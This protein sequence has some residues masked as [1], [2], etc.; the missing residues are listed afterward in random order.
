MKKKTGGKSAPAAGPPGRRGGDPAAAPPPPRPLFFSIPP[1]VVPP[2][3]PENHA[4]SRASLRRPRQSAASTKHLADSLTVFPRR[5]QDIGP[6]AVNIQ[7]AGDHKQQIGKAVQIFCG[8][9]VYLLRLAKMNHAS[10]RTPA[11][12]ARQMAHGGGLRSTGQDKFL[13]RR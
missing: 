7:Y 9:R 5:P 8:C 12:R 11:D 6:A 1:A 3:P 13:E 10:F 2:P 4:R